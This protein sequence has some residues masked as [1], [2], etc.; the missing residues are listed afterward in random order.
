MKAVKL[1]LEEQMILD[2]YEAGT[3]KTS[4]NVAEEM[5]IAR[6]ARTLPRGWTAA[7]I[8]DLATVVMGQSPSSD[9]YN[10]Q[11]IGLLFFKVRQNLP[12]Y[13]PSLKSGVVRQQKKPYLMIFCFL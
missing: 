9:T 2:A 1:D 8:F 12:N 7:T 6:A 3:L 13:I 11:K 10:D 5:N 4:Q